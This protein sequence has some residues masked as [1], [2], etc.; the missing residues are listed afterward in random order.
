[1]CCF[2]IRT[3]ISNE[4]PI[5]TWEWLRVKKCQYF[6][7]FQLAVPKCGVIFPSSLLS[8]RLRCAVWTFT[9][10]MWT[11]LMSPQSSSNTIT[12]ESA[13]NASHG[14]S[15]LLQV[16]QIDQYLPISSFKG[17]TATNPYSTTHTSTPYPMAMKSIKHFTG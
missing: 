13:P 10:I 5:T 8:Q 6:S 3:M 12:C 16:F 11:I 9:W 2:Y 4:N 17:V 1:M 14:K 7:H 15:L